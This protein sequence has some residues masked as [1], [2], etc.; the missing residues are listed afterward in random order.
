MEATP[1]EAPFKVGMAVI[2]N[3]A[4]ALS[5]DMAPLDSEM[6]ELA[7]LL[8]R[9]QALALQGVAKQRGLTAGQLLRRM[10]GAMV[11]AQPPSIIS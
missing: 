6:I 2:V 10:I 1:V 4:P 5:P 9:W 3:E 11:G 8:P 7:L